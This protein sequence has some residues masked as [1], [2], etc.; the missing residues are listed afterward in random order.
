MII[1]F[2]RIMSMDTTS[3]YEECENAKGKDKTKLNVIDSIG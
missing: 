2:S 3:T 1:M